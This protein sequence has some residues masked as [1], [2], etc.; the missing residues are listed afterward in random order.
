MRQMNVRPGET[1]AEACKKLA[2][3]AP[4][5]MVFNGLRVDAQ[6]GDSAET[7]YGRYNEAWERRHEE[8]LKTKDVELQIGR[9]Y[10]DMLEE[11]R[12]A[13]QFPTIDKVVETLVDAAHTRLAAPAPS[14]E[15]P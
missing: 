9:R 2:N 10:A 4:A 1:L 7:L 3:C 8:H 15:S 11:I 14:K 12:K 6:I 13:W 5:F